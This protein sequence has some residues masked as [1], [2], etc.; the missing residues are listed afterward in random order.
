MTP[1][2][3]VLVPFWGLAGGLIKVLDF[4]EHGCDA[5]FE[6]TLWAP[7]SPPKSGPMAS[8]PVLQR[9]LSKATRLARL[10]DLA[11]LTL[12]DADRLIFTE[13]HHARLVDRTGAKPE[14][15]I[16]LVQGTRHANPHWNEG[17]NFRLLHRPYVRVAVSEQVRDAIAAHVNPNL[18]LHTVVEGHDVDYFA[19]DR[20][21]AP[22]RDEHVVLY[23]TWKSDL[24]DRVAGLVTAENI[25]FVSI[26]EPVGW[27][28][29][30]AHYHAADI[31]LGAPGPEEGFY[32]PG[33][34]AMAAQSVVVMAL[35]GGN[36]AYARDGFNMLA[37]PYDDAQ[38]HA[39]AIVELA[40]D[41]EGMRTLAAQGTDTATQH[42]LERERR[43][44]RAIFWHPTD[45]YDEPSIAP[46]A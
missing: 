46:V 3:H 11:G 17:I 44:M 23:T 28:A 16:H 19:L 20:E 9:V 32:L 39:Q 13:P 14:Q 24:G 12:D 37:C 18:P 35:V 31:F 21:N 40:K 5:G 4:A 36:R 29:L 15:T 27:P 8:L 2:L 38:A 10:D 33:L 34:E 45:R 7:E 1:S 6:V 22:P 41:P 26:R 43:D 42:R 30:R 25:R